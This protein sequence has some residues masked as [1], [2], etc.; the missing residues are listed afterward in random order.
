MLIGEKEQKTNI[1]LKNVDDFETY[2][3]A[4][5]FTCYDSDDVTFTEWLYKLN[6]PEFK[7][8]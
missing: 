5:D 1:R 3:N 6:T 7:K 2:I 8:K 4:K